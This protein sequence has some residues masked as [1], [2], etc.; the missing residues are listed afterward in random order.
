MSK[1]ESKQAYDNYKYQTKSSFN[2]E[3]HKKKFLDDFMKFKWKSPY[4]VQY[5]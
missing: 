5:I 4:K 1:I 2:E 3:D